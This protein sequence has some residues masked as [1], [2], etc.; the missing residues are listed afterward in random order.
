MNWFQ[1]IIDFMSAVGQDVVDIPTIPSDDV[2]KLRK[3]LIEEEVVRELLVAI[4]KGDMVGI[5]DG[6]IDS[7][8]VILGTLVAY[9][10][11]AN[12]LWDEIHKTNMAK[13]GGEIR[14]DGKRLKP[15]NWK[16]P[17][18]FELLE[19]MGWSKDIGG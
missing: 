5:A 2:K 17:K 13:I 9:G 6:A 16:P 19:E 11:D 18:V 8:V 15:N 1:D 4:D 14:E 12:M 3:E 7:I 10:I